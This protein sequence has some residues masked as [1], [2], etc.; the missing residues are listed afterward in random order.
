MP[1]KK[2]A[3]V[4]AAAAEAQ[5]APDDP[6]AILAR[7]IRERQCQEEKRAFEKNEMIA[8]RT[9]EAME[10]VSWK[11]VYIE[12]EKRLDPAAWASKTAVV[13]PQYIIVKR[14][15]GNRAIPQQ[16]AKIHVS[17]SMT[18]GQ[19][20]ATVQQEFVRLQTSLTTAAVSA[21]SFAPDK[22]RLVVNGAELKSLSPDD[23]IKT[24]G[25]RSMMTV[26]VSFAM[27]T[28]LSQLLPSM[29]N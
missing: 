10:Q 2:P 14:L 12:K 16:A 11:C 25:I 17:D 29:V 24:V 20:K 18:V 5:P 9:V 7:E 13:S 19:L 1:P 6:A 4:E 28:N 23:L 3:Q 15:T 22:Q 21:A 26:H 27:P 8:R